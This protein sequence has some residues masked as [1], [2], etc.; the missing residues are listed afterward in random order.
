MYCHNCGSKVPTAASYCAACGTK[1]HVKYDSKTSDTTQSKISHGTPGLETVDT[2]IHVPVGWKFALLY[3]L[4]F[5]LYLNYWGYLCWEALY[6]S[7]GER[8]GSPGW[9]GL[10]VRITSF[11]LFPQI[12]QLARQSDYPRSHSPRLMAAMV[13]VLDVIGWTLVIL[14]LAWVPIGGIASLPILAL[15][16]VCLGLV[17]IVVSRVTKALNF[18]LQS[19]GGPSKVQALPRNWALALGLVAIWFWT[20]AS[21]VGAYQ[22]MAASAAP[23]SAEEFRTEWTE[24]CVGAGGSESYCSCVYEDISTQF[25]YEE[26]ANT[27]SDD[28][29]LDAIYQD[30]L[31][32]TT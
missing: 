9:R 7:T 1:V 6:R 2:L 12:L 20:C 25:T 8:T 15:G 11:S 18:V 29:R 30:C 17:L 14:S 21:I 27:Q 22:S 32:Q 23:D 24:G 19:E 28:P 5:G 13:L 3:L 26:L 31:N 10:F 16:A 4:T